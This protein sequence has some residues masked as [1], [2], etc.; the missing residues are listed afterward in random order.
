[1]KP[2][3]H[4]KE[5]PQTEPQWFDALVRLARYLRS[6]EGCPWDRKQTARSF[7]EYAREE[8]GEYIEAFDGDNAHIEEEWGDTLFTLLASAAAAESEG[9]FSI[10]QALERA[11]AKMI[12]RHGHIFGEFTAETPEDASEVWNQIKAQEKAEKERQAKGLP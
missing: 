1:M 8:A 11:H 12:R 2:Y 9:R 4:I 3:P 6:P 10:G 5:I 7:A